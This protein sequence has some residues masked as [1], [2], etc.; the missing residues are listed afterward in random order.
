M[1]LVGFCAYIPVVSLKRKFKAIV[2]NEANLDVSKTSHEGQMSV[3]LP[4]LLL[5]A[6]IGTAEQ[7]SA[8]RTVKIL[9]YIY[10]IADRLV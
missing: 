9:L 2:L 7:F 8:I 6:I 3:E 1:S 5:L 4:H 10:C